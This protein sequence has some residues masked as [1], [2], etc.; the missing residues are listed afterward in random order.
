VRGI[1]SRISVSAEERQGE[2]PHGGVG[3]GPRSP[4]R[5]DLAGEVNLQIREIG[6]SLGVAADSS[7]VLTF[8]CQCGC[9]AVVSL[10]PG[11]F[12]AAGGAWLEAHGPGSRS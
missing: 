7:E 8:F 10:T 1:P 3:E 5:I 2:Q 4:S 9:F 11:A 6:R 12:D